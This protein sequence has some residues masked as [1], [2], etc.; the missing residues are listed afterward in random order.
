MELVFSFKKNFN[1]MLVFYVFQDAS[2]TRFYS[3]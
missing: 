3:L 2:L 1:R